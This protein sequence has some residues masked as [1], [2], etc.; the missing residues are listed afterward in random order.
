[1]YITRKSPLSGRTHTVDIPT[2]TSAIAA[3][4]EGMLAQ[5]AFP[6]LNSDQRE[7]IMTG[8]TAAEWDTYF[9]GESDE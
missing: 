9:P 6:T 2:S 4:K 3:W 7:F 5:D 8:I 1:M